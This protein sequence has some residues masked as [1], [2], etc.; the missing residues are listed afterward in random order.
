MSLR[1]HK[2]E[3]HQGILQSTPSNIHPTD[4]NVTEFSEK[5]PSDAVL[6]QQITPAS[7]PN[8]DPNL[9]LSS[10][11]SLPPSESMLSHSSADIL[12]G[13]NILKSRQLGFP[14]T[15]SWQ[16]DY[17]FVGSNDIT[18]SYQSN[19]T[20]SHAGEPTSNH[21]QLFHTSGVNPQVRT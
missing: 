5:S 8:V 18:L 6:D 12:G 9:G 3:A 21:V 13:S 20:C 10:E 4:N 19:P 1:S 16:N 14:T 2:C 17:I 11:L 7:G 15:S